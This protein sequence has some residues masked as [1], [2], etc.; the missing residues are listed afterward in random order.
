MAQA[1]GSE[2]ITAQVVARSLGAEAGGRR[3]PVTAENVAEVRVDRARL[4]KLAERLR[5]LGFKVEAIGVNMVSISGD[6]Q[7]FADAFNL[8]VGRD[9]SSTPGPFP[10][11]AGLADLAEQVIVPPPPELF[12]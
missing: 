7:T 3:R 8:P 5:G 9:A 1:A 12:R 10:V 2:R 6:R 11:P 4:E